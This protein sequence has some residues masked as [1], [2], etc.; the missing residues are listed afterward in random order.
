M[1]TAY[2]NFTI[3]LKY[4]HQK[5]KIFRILRNPEDI[6]VLENNFMYNMEDGV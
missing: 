1:I 4:L 6:Q 3:V 5:K 2:N